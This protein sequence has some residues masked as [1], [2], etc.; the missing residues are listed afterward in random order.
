MEYCVT[1]FNS[2]ICPRQ[3]SEGRYIVG[4]VV[5]YSFKSVFEIGCYNAV[6]FFLKKILENVPLLKKCI[7]N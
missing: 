2:S 7:M 4:T 1:Q 5:I 3:M 6:L